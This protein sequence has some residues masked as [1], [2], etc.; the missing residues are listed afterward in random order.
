MNKHKSSFTPSLQEDLKCAPSK[1]YDKEANTCFSLEQ[2]EKMAQAY[3]MSRKAQSLKPIKLGYNFENFK[4]KVEYKKYLLKQL[5]SKLDKVCNKQVCLL[6][7]NFVR[8]IGDSDIMYHTFRPKGPTYKYK[9]LSTSDINQILLQYQD[10]YPDFLFI[11]A[12][13]I[14]FKDIRVPIDFSKNTLNKT[15]TNMY[16]GKKG[17]PK[18]NKLGVVFNLDRHNQPG[19]HWVGLYANLEKKQIYFFDSYGKMPHK[20]ILS[21]MEQL[22]DWMYTKD[23]SSK[24]FGSIIFNSKGKGNVDFAD[25][26]Y[27]IIRHQYKNSECGVYSTHFIIK[28][29]EGESFEKFTKAKI[30]DDVINLYREK[31]FRFQ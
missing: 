13:P 7:E 15:L 14:D 25:I 2:L 18:I 27:N 11:G 10:V 22:R 8:T 20:N 17:N 21:F 3:N 23:V 31:Y 19:S 29:L 26:R 24:T 1:E 30:P 9:W 6:Q 12:I 4:N 16:T 28:M 5:T